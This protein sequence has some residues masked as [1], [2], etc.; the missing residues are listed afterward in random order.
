MD[1]TEQESGFADPVAEIADTFSE[2]A[3]ALF[4]A[5][6]VTDTLNQIVNVAV[7]TIEG[8]DFAGILL[9]AG[10]LVTTPAGTD[11]IVEKID[12][13]QQRTGEGPCLEAIAQQ[14]MFYA[15]DLATEPRWPRFAAEAEAI[16]MRSVLA[17]PMA[18]EG[19]L[20]ALNLYA[21]FPEAFGV[22][23]RGKG[24]ILASLAS[25][26]LSAAHSHED[27]ELRADHLHNALNA[28]R[29]IG[30]AQGI[31][32]ERERIS[33][34]QAFDVLRRASQHLNVKLREVAQALVDTGER[35]DT[36]PP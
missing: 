9:K 12:G 33:A 36:G 14:L 24:V 26:A 18:S 30:Q 35:P 19:G 11:A 1:S 15:A 16:G 17:L 32:M 6:S 13:F 7:A 31:L 28:R 27:D 5:G 21:R 20:G 34:D 3:Q 2:T 22:V 8:C 4:S 29:V 10:D 23:D 25:V